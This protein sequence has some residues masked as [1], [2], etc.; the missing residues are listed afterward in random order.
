MNRIS[1][2]AHSLCQQCANAFR[3]IH[4]VRTH[5]RGGGGW[6]N[7]YANVLVN[8]WRHKNCVQGGGGGQKSW[9]FCVRTLWMALYPISCSGYENV[10]I[11]DIWARHQQHTN[12]TIEFTLNNSIVIFEMKK[13]KKKER[14]V[15]LPKNISAICDIIMA[16]LPNNFFLFNNSQVQ[17][18]FT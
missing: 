12:H 7:A 13:K 9:K 11:Q 6:A 2:V 1:A 3:G 15:E 18:I 16:L 4:K 5:G 14:R 10:Y 8:G 17:R